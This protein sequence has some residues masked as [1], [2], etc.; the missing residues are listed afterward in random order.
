MDF[1]VRGNHQPLG[2]PAVPLESVGP[3]RHN[4]NKSSDFNKWA[5]LGAV[6]FIFAL[7]II[8]VGSIFLIHYS[9][10]NQYSYVN[11]NDFQ[12][13]D[14]SIG[15]STSGDQI[16][17]GQVKDISSNYLVLYDIYYIPASTSS[18][19]S[20]TLQPLVCQVDTPYNQMVINLSSVNWWENLQN[21]GKVAQSILS[22]QKQNPKGA[23]CAALT[24]SSTT[25]PATTTPSTTGS[26]TTK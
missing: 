25:T 23:N 18:T 7:A 6:L 15:G 12:A 3:P 13:V 26:T 14:V 8:A 19:S 10:V 21:T 20:I 17:F 22:Y 5:R 24:S 1:S 11:K 9:N 16:F 2:T 4:K